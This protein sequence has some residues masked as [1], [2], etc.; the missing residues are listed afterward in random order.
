MDIDRYWLISWTCYGNWL[1]GA[2]RGFVGNVREPD[3]TQVTHNILGTPFDED[4]PLLEAWVIQHMK[5]EPITLQQSHAD[6]MIAQYQ[7]T[8]RIRS[9]GVEV[10]RVMFSQAQTGVA[11]PGS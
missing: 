8:A 5:G 7:E 1:P 10:G 11:V 2:A 9:S 3:G 4:I 6:A